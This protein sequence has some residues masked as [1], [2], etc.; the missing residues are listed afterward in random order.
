M[1]K[2][3]ILIILIGVLI[4]GFSPKEVVGVI[5]TNKG[6]IV[7]EFYPD[8]APKHVESFMTHAKNGYYD[9]T[10]FHRVIP[11]FMIQGG[12]PNSKS[13]DRGMHGMGGYAGKYYGIGDENNSKSWMLPAEFSTTPHNRGILSMARAQSPNSAGSQFFICVADAHFLNNNY[14]VFGKV[15]KGMDVADQIVNSSRDKGDNPLERIE[16]NIKIVPK[17]SVEGLE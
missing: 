11:G 16:M 9:G 10:T 3:L 7:I 13:E 8:I 6:D 15:L 4:M 12:D 17:S 5:S 2:K 1:L 14:T